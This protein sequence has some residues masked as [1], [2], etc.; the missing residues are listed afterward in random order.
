M[1][2]P[3]LSNSLPSS[4]A[5][6]IRVLVHSNLFISLA[7]T[8][9]ALSTVLLAELA[10]DY[11][12]LFIV[13]AVTMFVYSFNRITDYAE[14]KQNTPGRATFIRRY[15]KQ[16][17]GVGIVLYALATAL[18][19]LQG[20]PAAPAM[21]VPLA[22][23]V[24][25]SVIGLKKLLLVKNL[26]VG[27]SWGLIPLGVGVYYGVLWTTDI[28]FMAGFV[29]VMLT[30]AAAVFDIKDI[31]GDSAAGISTLPVRYSSRLTRRFAAGATVVV[32]LA[33]VLLVEGGILGPIYLLLLLFTA[34]VF[35]YSL[36][37]T[38]DCGPLFYGF[39]IDG[40]H[41]LLAVIL[42]VYEA[43]SRGVFSF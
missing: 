32:A 42:L 33:V 24:L 41:I 27:L 5:T 25:Y 20:I 29:T 3:T 12:P 40:E 4:L 28:L 8:S 22:V 2:T 15:G 43:V 23:A 7:A 35:G 21:G 13:F 26:L 34:Y 31:E 30:I 19:V 14:D 17:L 36:V 37:A 11:I 16:L 6:S 1:A 38:P 10:L 39:V 9:V 18:A